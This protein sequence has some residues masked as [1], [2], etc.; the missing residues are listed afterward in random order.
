MCK[1]QEL[2]P[3]YS[4]FNLQNC[5]LRVGAFVQAS[6]ARVHIVYVLYDRENLAP[7]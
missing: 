6:K 7:I 3:L 1:M 5:K 4:W 2:A